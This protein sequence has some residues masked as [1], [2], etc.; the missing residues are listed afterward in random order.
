[1]GQDTIIMQHINSDLCAVLSHSVISDCDPVAPLSLGILQARILEYVAM[2]SSRGI[3][4]IQ[5]SNPGLPDCRR[6]LYQQSH[7]GSD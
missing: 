1:M 7:Q 5:G 2:L 6:I 4:S 3:F